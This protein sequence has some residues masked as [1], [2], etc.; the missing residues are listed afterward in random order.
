MRWATKERSDGF[1]EFDRLNDVGGL[2]ERDVFG[3]TDTV[4]PNKVEAAC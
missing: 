1:G 3:A 4:V 2:G